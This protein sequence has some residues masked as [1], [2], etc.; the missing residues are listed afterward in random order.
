MAA[1][2]SEVRRFQTQLKTSMGRAGQEAG[3]ALGQG[4][5]RTA[6]G[7]L[8]DARDRFVKGGRDL[9][10]GLADGIKDG[11]DRGTRIVSGF[12]SSTLAIFG[13]LGPGIGAV[14]GAGLAGVAASAGTAAGAITAAV[15]GALTAVGVVS[16]AQSETVRRHWRTVGR[17]VRAGLANAARPLEESAIRASDVARRTFAQLQPYLAHFFAGA[18][19]AVDR[20]VQSIGDGVASLGPALVP[21][22]RGFSAVLDAIS[23][24]SPAI[25]GSLERAMENLGRTAEEHADDIA[26]ALEFVAG[27]A[28]AATRALGVLAD[29]W[30]SLTSTVKGAGETTRSWGE[31][32]QRSLHDFYKSLGIYT[33]EMREAEERWKAADAAAA[34]NAG[35]KQAAQATSDLSSSARDASAGL[36]DLAAEME[37]LTGPALDAAEAQIRVEEAIDRATESIKENGRT[38]DVHTE[39]GRANREAML[40]IARTA[41]ERIASMQA[42]G[43]STEKIATAYGR[44]RKELISSL[45]AAGATKA[46]A[47]RLAEAWLKVPDSVQTEVRGNISDLEAKLAVAKARLRDPKLTRPERA[48]LRGDIRELQ[49][50]IARAKALLNS[51]RDKTVHITTVRNTVYT[52]TGLRQGAYA[53]ARAH[54]GIVG[55]GL[56]GGLGMRRFAQGGVAGSGV[57]GGA[58][59]LVGEQGPELVRL[60]YGS[61]VMPAGQTRSL[62]SGGF[63]SV[64]MAFRPGGVGGGGGLGD[65]A[66]SLRD[67]ADTLREIVTL[68][69][70]IDKLTGSVF[71]QTRALMGYEEAWDR[72]RTALKENGK[73]L[74]ITKEKGREN[75]AA[76][77]GL[78]EAAHQVVIAMREKGSSIT[79]VT[80]KM[81]EQRR[82]FISMARSFGLT[83]KQA[84]AMADRLGL[85]PSKVKG[86]LV[87]EQRDLAYNKKVEAAQGK[88]GGGPAG[89]WTLVGERGAELVRLPY[90]SNVTPAGAS[91]AALAGGGWSG[92]R[93][94]H[95]TLQIGTTTLGELII[96]PLRKAVRT[97]GGNVQA[98]LGRG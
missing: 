23:A 49:A 71:G 32:V 67:I 18:K 92:P 93:E 52:N 63:G 51:L 29:E 54:G 68:R 80:K 44:Y 90:G 83:S 60:P 1:A 76:L 3:A 61:S 38:L 46:E 96:D 42:E 24:R 56:G 9:G 25:F 70:S 65:A 11:T 28:E 89:G 58:T 5:A 26:A 97:R 48:K 14:V 74:N 19:P 94:L 73:T 62:M 47:E 81:A 55:G 69:D 72:A 17:E 35:V 40:E 77:L 39:K 53:T 50:A 86:I 31:N 33:D 91:A 45:R 59:A 98:V 12:A 57:A 43:A 78:A 8:R 75:R 64:S 66:G 27:S 82:E 16:A 34:S 84:G 22:Q 4:L 7:R 15:G 79:A 88:A 21:L 10:D 41:Q 85:V 95:V 20:F 2:Q 6:D 87:K 37:E 36:R 13:R 30:D